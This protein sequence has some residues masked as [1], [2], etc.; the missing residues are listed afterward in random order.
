MN[1]PDKVKLLLERLRRAL[2]GVDK[3]KFAML[4]DNEIAALQELL[5]DITLL[6]TPHITIAVITAIPKERAAFSAM[7]DDP[8]FQ[9]FDTDQILQ[10]EVGRLR[11]PR[12]NQPHS[13]VLAQ[14][15]KMGNNSAAITATHLMNDYP[16]V[17]DVLMVGIA[18]GI[19]G[20][21]LS[22]EQARLGDVRQIRLGDIVVS[23]D[24]GVVQYDMI[25][26]EIRKSTNRHSAPPPSPRLLSAVDKLEAGRIQGKY[27]WEEYISHGDKLENSQR[28][29]DEM[30]PLH[31]AGDGN[32]T[33][34]ADITRRPGK[35]KIHYGAIG[36]ANT[37]LK[38]PTKR[39]S[40][41]E[42]LKIIAVEMEG[43][44][45][46]D[47][48]WVTGAGYLLIRG[49]CDYC[50]DKKND[51]WQG[52]AAVVASAYARALIETLPPAAP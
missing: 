24:E 42:T 28:P 15:F 41:H 49:I 45:I 3:R 44:G 25:K 19:P 17:R 51:V 4:R 48:T 9:Y 5:K 12:N 50:D 13:V 39:D 14:A 7:M 6:I 16:H 40:L 2:T 36:S 37:L 52:Y 11:S 26:V 8:Q 1:M 32:N 21:V 10:Y 30:D 27:P 38:D 22:P 31:D 47:A 29:A 18:G 34:P 23:R 33:Q 20:N 43:S 35:P 46:A